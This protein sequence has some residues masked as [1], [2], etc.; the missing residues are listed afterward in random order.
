MATD[1]YRSHWE[2]IEPERLAVY[3]QIFQWSPRL[4]PLLAGLDIAEGMVVVDYGCGPGW[5]TLEM[6]RRA[7]A[8]GR[9][10]GCDLNTEFLARAA[11]HAQES[12]LAG[13]V[14]WHNVTDDRI[15]LPGGSADRVFCKNVLEYVPSIDA[16]VAEF[17]RVLRPGGIMRLVDSDWDMLLIEPIG[18][19]RTREL[20]RHA[21]RAYN[22]AQAGRH[23]YGAA[24]RAGFAE[25]EVAVAAT[26]DTQ[27][28]ILPVLMNIAGYATGGGYPKEEATRLLADVNAAKDNGELLVMLPQ[29]IITAKAP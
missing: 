21:R 26:P 9:A 22:D 8:S 3:D 23:L 16:I 6:A 29:F 10:V 1:Y 18:E 4:D 19:E 20:M 15:P 24:R 27:G 28:G 17:R 2:A 25:V 13:R 7:G 5:V 14:T 12:G 11:A